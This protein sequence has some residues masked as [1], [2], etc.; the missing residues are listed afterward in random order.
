VP[1]SSKAAAAPP[2]YEMSSMK[3]WLFSRVLALDFLRPRR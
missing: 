2:E 1:L 3:E